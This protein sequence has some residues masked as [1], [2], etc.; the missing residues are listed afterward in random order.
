MLD[1]LILLCFGLI[2]V[3]IIQFFEYNYMN[4]IHNFDDLTY[5]DTIVYKLFL[6]KT[7]PTCLILLLLMGVKL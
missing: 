6:F 5:V 4:G 2:V 3:F 1:Y 7:I